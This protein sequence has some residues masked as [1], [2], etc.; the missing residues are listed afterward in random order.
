M[1]QHA[2]VKGLKPSHR[3]HDHGVKQAM[4]YVL[5][6]ARMPSVLVETSFISNAS[7]E[8]L[9]RSD[10]YRQKIAEGIADG[11]TDYRRET[12]MAFLAQ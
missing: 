8:K 2:L 9:L 5:H 1:V 11:V 3:P 4:F 6:G 12:Q 7:E 10:A